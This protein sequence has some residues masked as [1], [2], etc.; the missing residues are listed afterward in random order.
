MIIIRVEV[1]SAITGKVTEIARMKIAN[2]GTSKSVKL[3]DYEGYVLRKPAF[4]HRTRK[5]SVKGHR[6][7]DLPVW[8][9]VGKMLKSMGY[10][11]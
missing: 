11:K 4:T 5:G 2:T 1:W 7:Q 3:G 9:L 8:S 10:V 6:R